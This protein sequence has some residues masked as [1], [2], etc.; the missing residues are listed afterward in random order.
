MGHI[1]D[2]S[3]QYFCEQRR[4]VTATSKGTIINKVEISNPKISL[5]NCIGNPPNFT[6]KNTLAIVDSG[7]NI[8]LAKQS[9]TTMDPV[10]ISND[11]TERLP[12]GVTIDS[13]LIATLQLPGISKQ[14]RQIHIF[15][16]T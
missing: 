10:I 8:H 6:S 7:V 9:T 1:Q 11:I 12:N 5:I 3:C 2:I 14:A 15:P 16:K 4:A 13:S